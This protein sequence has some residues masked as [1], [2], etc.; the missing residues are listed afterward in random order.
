MSHLS[1]SKAIK[2]STLKF[3]DT[4]T[5]TRNVQPGQNILPPFETPV[6]R[7]GLAICFDVSAKY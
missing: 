1:S 7:V 4:A 3:T 6:G 5:A 2:S